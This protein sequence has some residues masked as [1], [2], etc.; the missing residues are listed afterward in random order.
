MPAVNAAPALLGRAPTPIAQGLA[1]TPPEPLIDLSVRLSP[2][3]SGALRGA[4]AFMWLYTALVS[5][6]LPQQSGALQLLARCG[7]E[8]AAGV[9][10]LV[11]SCALNITLGVLALVR[12]TPWLYAV[13]AGA[14]LGYTITAAWHMPELTLD[15]CGPLVKNLPVLMAVLVLWMARPGAAPQTA[16]RG[17]PTARAVAPGDALLRSLLDGGAPTSPANR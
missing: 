10:A 15:H 11:F 9:A 16:P 1:I 5:A 6:W 4:L 2:V 8:G 13:Q 7:F 14:V 3:M 12:P 17:R